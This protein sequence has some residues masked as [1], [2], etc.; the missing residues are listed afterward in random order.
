MYYTRATG[1][2]SVPLIMTIYTLLGT[3]RKAQAKKVLDMW[4]AVPNGAPITHA[5]HRATWKKYY[6]KYKETWLR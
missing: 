2:N 6:A 3:R 1:R 5:R 4:R